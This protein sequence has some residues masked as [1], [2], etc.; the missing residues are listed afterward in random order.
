MKHVFNIV[1][2]LNNHFEKNYKIIFFVEKNEAQTV[3]FVVAKKVFEKKSLWKNFFL[4][5]NLPVYFCGYDLQ[6]RAR[7]FFFK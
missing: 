1:S 7:K 5:N 3:G 2:K 6:N 4:K